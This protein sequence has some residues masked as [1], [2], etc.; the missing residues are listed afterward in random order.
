M[1]F[2]FGM[3]DFVKTKMETLCEKRKQFAKNANTLQ[4][5]QT[6]L[7]SNK[8]DIKWH[9]VERAHVA[10]VG[11]LLIQVLTTA[12]GKWAWQ[13]GNH[14]YYERGFAESFEQATQFV[15]KI[16]LQYNEWDKQ[17]NTL[18]FIDVLWKSDTANGYTGAWHNYEF[19]VSPIDD[20][21]QGVWRYDIYHD[22]GV[23]SVR[24]GV[25]QSA[26]QARN[27]CIR[28]VSIM[29]KNNHPPAQ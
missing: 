28:A 5:T 18:F 15:E 10:N 23:R 17:N 20:I 9:K 14:I 1:Q 7:Q 2:I 8:T 11:E 16:S 27:A 29:M 19:W 26:N 3:W 6:A 21:Q 22:I 24:Y 4:K 25:A 12:N 13:L